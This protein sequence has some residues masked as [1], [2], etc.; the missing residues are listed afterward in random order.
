M[1][2]GNA[3]MKV[4]P[5]SIGTRAANGRRISTTGE[6]ALAEAQGK[7]FRLAIFGRTVALAILAFAFLAGYHFPINVEVC[8][9]T[10]VLALAGLVALRTIGT[11]REK[12]SRFI[13]FSTDAA[14]VSA[15]LAIAPLSSGDDIPQNLVFFTT[16]VQF[17]YI[18]IAASI[19]TLSPAL[20]V[21]TGA[22]CVLGLTLSTLWIA[23]GMESIL[24]FRDLPIAPS[25]DVFNRIVLNPDFLGIES[26]VEEALILSAVT[27]IAAIAVYGVRSVVLARVS[28]EERR[29]HIQRVFGKYVPATVISELET[30]GQLAPQSREATLLFADVEGFT[31]ISE[32]LKP[33]EVVQLLNE[34]FAAISDKIAR[35]GG[36]VVN[37]FGDAVIAAFNAPLPLERHQ[38]GAVV[39][40]RDIL[41]ALRTTEFYGHRLR[42]RIGIASGPVAAGTVGS[43][44]KLSFTLYGDTV[45]LSQRLEALN[46]ELGT[47]CLMCGATYDA[48]RH[49]VPGIRSLGTCNVRNKEREVEVYTID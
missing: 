22:C 28:E 1:S 34:L 40:A 19:L 23:A 9:F 7:G 11:K 31:S 10:L 2:V 42:M 44:E 3:L 36:L 41:D 18:V 49:E 37:Y 20:V 30:D 16:R 8:L 46:K 26:R 21:W 13:F 25:A 48:V 45:N 33:H 35:Q 5:G 43:E 47:N 15:I 32:K 12:V 14:L 38:L 27:G 4:L 6:R 29:Q 17:F 24:S 39:A